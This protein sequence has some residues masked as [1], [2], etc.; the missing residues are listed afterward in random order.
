MTLQIALHPGELWWGGAVADGQL[1]PFG[2]VPHTRDLGLSAGR[3][4]DPGAGA[5]QSAPL[6]VSSAGRYLW[7]DEP[8]A[9]TIGDG[10]LR[11]EGHAEIRN[12]GTTLGDAYRAA[13]AAFFPPSGRTP[14]RELF[15]GPQWNTWIENPFTP[16][17]D[18]VLAY[19]RR[20]LDDGLPPGVLMIDD[21]W[22]P[23]Y[24]TWEFDRS[25]FPDPAGMIA[26]LRDLGF[27]V[28]L[29]IVPFV[30]PD[31]APFRLLERR[32]LLVRTRSGE[33]AVR[34]WWNGFSAQLDTTHPD[35]VDWLT[36]QLD[37]LDR[38]CGVAGFK[39]DG[40]DLR[41]YRDG[42][43]FHSGGA[44]ADLVAAWS[45]LG[46][47]YPF[48]EF[49]SGWKHGAQ[50]LA[51]R[52]HDKPP[53]WTGEGLESLIP[54]LIAQA[55]IGH[56]F[57]CPDMIGGGELSAVTGAGTVDQELFVRYTQV[58]ALAPMTQFSMHPG[59]VLDRTHLD[60]VRAA[61]A[62]RASLLP[63]ILALADHAATTGEP[64]L[65][66]LAYHHPGTEHVT[67]QFLLGPDVLVAPVLTPGA[68]S[69]T[70]VLPPGSWTGHDGTVHTGPATITVPV[71]LE[72]L[73]RFTRTG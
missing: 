37:T 73:P 14:A 29:W 34:R 72:T 33:T 27:P 15:T 62:V 26:T 42:D 17:Q 6:L 39:F 71:T 41:D 57:T 35:A 30:S 3:A 67:D 60:A 28:M 2:P 9:F 13:C 65:R 53:T 66:P 54:E 46:L 40:G 44:P 31:T 7:S 43:L 49:R 45:S 36:A 32:G 24:G 22:S 20:V 63:T 50:P 64:I 70:V 12:G 8:F 1:M 25:R 58:A 59:R 52:L 18:G 48:N 38:D 51:E 55:M 11:A 10:R 69:R 68:T 16:T 56:A 21:C 23:A 5:N 19:A 47:R 61:L 4:G